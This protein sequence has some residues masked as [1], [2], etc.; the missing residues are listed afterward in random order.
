MN[1][2]N[3]SGGSHGTATRVADAL[4]AI[5]DH[6]LPA[7]PGRVVEVYGAA[8]ALG[9]ALAARLA[10]A[11]AR[12]PLP[13]VVYVV[14]DD[15]LAEARVGDIGF[16]LPPSGGTADNPIS[17]SPVLHLPAPELSPYAEVQP[18]RRA[19]LAR[20]AV[21]YR[22]ACGPAPLVLVTSAAALIRRVFPRRAF[23]QRCRVITARA[24]VNRDDTVEALL[25]AGYSRTSLVEDP[26]TFAV[27]G[28]VIDLF[29]PI[30]KHPV[31]VELFGD[32]LESIR[33]FDAP[34][35]RTL[36]TIDEVHIHPV[37][38]T[39]RTEGA[40]P[41][42]QVLAA[43]DKAAYP[44]SK[45]RLLVEQV[46]SGESFFG[47]EALAPIFH[48][49]LDPLTAYLPPDAL[50]VVEDP[51]AVLEDAH[52]ALVKLRETAVA[53]HAEHRLALNPTAFLLTDDECAATLSSRHQVALHGIE[54]ERAANSDGPPRIRLVAES[55]ATLRAELHQARAEHPGEEPD[56]GR[57]LRE[58]INGWLRDGYHVAVVAANRAH[59]DRMFALLTS[60]GL[61]PAPL[62][63]ATD[64]L[65]DVFDPDRGASERAVLSVLVGTLTHGFRLPASRLVLIAEDE[66][67]G[68]HQAREVRTIK[69]P[70]LGDLG[71]VAE[72]DVV[73]HDDHGVGRYRGLKKLQVRGVTQDF[74]HLE[75]DGGLV[76]VPVYRIGLLH[77]Y[78][79]AEGES[80]RLDKLGGKTWAEKRRRV[81]VEARKIAEELLQLY[82]QR[83]AL[84]GH[85][86]PAPDAVFRELEETFPFEET[87]D[88]AKAIEAVLGDMQTGRPMDR[89]VC[90]DV[91]YG[92]TEVAL[93][94]A[95]LAVLGGKQV[96]VLAPTTVLAE[97]HFVTF[98]ERYTDLP[99]RIAA[100]SRFRARAEQQKTIAE[101]AAGKIDLVIGTHRVL[102]RDVRF[103]DLG[104]VI[105]DEEQR[106][107]V[108]HKERL[109]ELRTQVDVLT[110]TATP[111]PRT[112]QMAI[113]GL[114]EI[115][116]IATPPADRLA[117][118]TFVCRW[119]PV[120]LREAIQKELTRGGQLFF[121][122]NRIEDLAEWMG[123]L[124]ELCPPETRLAMAHGQMA[125]GVLEK[126]MVDFVDG[127]IDILCCTTI[128]ESGLDIPRANTMIVNHA[129]RFGL[130]QLYQMRGRIGR[131]RERAFCYLVV[132]NESRITPEAKQRLAV[133]Q[134]F[135]EL[136]A[137]FQVATHDL[138][139][140]GAGELLGDKQSGAV[141]AVGFETFARILEEAVAELKGE[142]IRQ[143]R[144]PEVAV[145][146][147]AFL[148]DD[149]VPDTGQ[150]LDF[151]RRLARAEN[152]DQIGATLT[153]LEDRYGPLPEEAKLLGEVMGQ[154]LLARHIGAL[155][156]EL[157][158]LRLML[159]LG[160]D[161]PLDPAR[162]MRMV[163][164]KH[165][166]WKLTPDM[167]LTYTFD[168][169]EKRDR[170]SFARTRLTEVAA[171]R[172]K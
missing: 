45:T 131:S 122:H 120:L 53:R 4:T 168:E 10:S 139:I 109:K 52:R 92:K 113:G 124:R 140:R 63:K 74:L 77:R 161:S 95:M 136:G 112:L 68:K 61:T 151:Y 2:L 70:A 6:F 47:M 133:L 71:E 73:V 42:A 48:A 102:S 160:A 101:L 46:E 100:L 31:R 162:V 84:S 11:R 81:S 22:L 25:A 130:A 15:D 82:A 132:P 33:L 43:A 148:P 72:G 97:Q 69:T 119:D 17:A 36:R 104:L 16:F 28:A 111:I 32:E 135:T 141:A 164:A 9:G 29:P 89:L 56:L 110:L 62:G 121:V 7:G 149:Y 40:D 75:Y 44:S 1:P 155:S 5:Q 129:D 145:D 128:I 80:I 159:A 83:A 13:A 108:A 91:G 18:D 94:A 51:E 27:R 127:K 59:A 55:N 87:P 156:Y 169:V 125:E 152:E 163:Q 49:Q 60:W 146:V 39:I 172:A 57:P 170:L 116:I 99:V 58:R 118:R 150:R 19:L 106:F 64:A 23:E 105:I 96:A 54:L 154:K 167:R 93:R 137:G 157:G 90:G 38:E 41:R 12:S 76:Y 30:Y 20:M 67:F 153:E 138:E 98:S 85:A 37:R 14:G 78:A 66:I 114:R 79:G 24:A 115:S 50:F 158:P 142:P 88:Q 34:T 166:R 8:G 134:R 147:P 171:L 126:V 144:D 143:D 117:I 65:A 165:S 103:K 3:G 26:G 123:K 21:L 107:G 35:Q 86:F